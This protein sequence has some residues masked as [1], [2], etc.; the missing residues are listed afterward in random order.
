MFRAA[1]IVP[2]RFPVW[3]RKTLC[4]K[5]KE[6]VADLGAVFDGGKQVTIHSWPDDE[7]VED[8][9]NEGMVI[10]LHLEVISEIALE[11]IDTNAAIPLQAH[12]LEHI[13]PAFTEN[14]EHRRP[15]FHLRAWRQLHH[16]LQH[17]PRRTRRDRLL[18]S[19][20]IGRAERRIE[21]A[22]VIPKIGHRADGRTRIA[23][24]CFLVDR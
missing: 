11:A 20:T 16:A 5:G 23:A 14:F 18:T 10:L 24:D 13:L 12:L 2:E 6:S 8:G 3:T 15:Q 4:M 19:R 17:L 21:H 22:E 9:F 7:P 1:E